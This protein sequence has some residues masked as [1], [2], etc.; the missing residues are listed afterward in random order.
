MILISGQ[1]E[2]LQTRKDK[3]IKLTFGT[4]ELTPNQCTDLFNLN[5]DFCYL[6][7]KEE[8][9]NNKET[10]II[11]S[12][13]ADIDNSKTPSQRL[14]GVLFKLY[15]Q[16]SEGFKDFS[17]YYLSKMELITNHYKAKIDG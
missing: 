9:F 14:R 6:A 8:P 12:L 1:I 5:Q 7:I 16:D 17:N 4:Q 10:D 15:E 11:D 13:K 2:S 3:T